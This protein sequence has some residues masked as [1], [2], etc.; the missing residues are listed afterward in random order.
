[1]KVV[2][3]AVVIFEFFL[4][5]IFARASFARLDDLRLIQGHVHLPLEESD[6]E[7]EAHLNAKSL[8]T[9]SKKQR[10]S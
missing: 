3:S 7:E 5:S 2:E 9:G 1:M 4:L 10:K 8:A 6:E